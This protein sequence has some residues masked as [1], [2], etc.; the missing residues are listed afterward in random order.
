ML[1]RQLARRKLNALDFAA[2]DGLVEKF[3]PEVLFVLLTF[4]LCVDEAFWGDEDEDED[5]DENSL[6]VPRKIPFAH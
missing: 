2:S 6:P 1:S 4:L 3:A 5:D